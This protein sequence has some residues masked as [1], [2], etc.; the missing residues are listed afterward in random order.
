MVTEF[1]KYIKALRWLVSGEDANTG[2]LALG[3]VCTML[4]RTLED[5]GSALTA[6]EL[7]E[8]DH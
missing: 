3:P 5:D 4:V 7:Q 6:Y 8:F 2:G 1:I